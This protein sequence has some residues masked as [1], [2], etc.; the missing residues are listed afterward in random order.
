MIRK[1][2]PFHLSSTRGIV[3]VVAFLSSAELG[4]IFGYFPALNAAKLSP[5]EALRHE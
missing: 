5:I 1:F 2:C 4:V 3:V